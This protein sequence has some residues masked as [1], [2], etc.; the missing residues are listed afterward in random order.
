MRKI[1]ILFLVLLASNT[2]IF[3]QYPVSGHLALD[4]PHKWDN[5]IYLS[6]VE[7][8][9]NNGEPNITVIAATRID[10]NGFFAFDQNV[11][12]DTDQIYQIRI[13]PITKE[14]KKRI[15]D[16]VKNF[17]LFIASKKDTVFFNKDEVL[18]GSY[19]TNNKADHEWQK[20]KKFEAQYENLTTDFDPKKYLME[21]KGYVKDSLQTLLVKLIGIKRLDDQ[22]LL[23][24]DIKKNPEYYLE[25]LNELKA[26]ELDPITYLYFENKLITITHKFTNRK[27]QTS[28]W[29]NGLTLLT[30]GCLI[31]FILFL[32]KKRV[33]NSIPLSKQEKVIKALIKSGK[34]NKEIAS[35]LFISLSTVKTHI[36][37]IYTKLNINNRNELINL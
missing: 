6:K 2:T 21:T 10:K 29:I 26:S 7:H 18:F 27:Y 20:L 24:K 30:I 13:N 37:N 3:A 31:I 5:N 4:H 1:I 8:N 16:T 14:E 22:D 36:T 32:K 17:R 23:V 25:F 34:S 12:E 19:T 11:F 28:L 15:S 33:H 35:E 9:Q